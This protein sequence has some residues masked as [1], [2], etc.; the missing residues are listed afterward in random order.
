MN[1]NGMTDVGSTTRTVDERLASIKHTEKDVVDQGA[2][3]LRPSRRRSGRVLPRPPR[4]SPAPSSP[5][6]TSS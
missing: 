5:Y 4:T 6:R 1:K 3:L 2:S